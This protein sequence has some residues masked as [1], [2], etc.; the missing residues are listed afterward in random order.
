[1]KRT[2]GIAGAVLA[3]L[4]LIMG[5]AGC[6]STLPVGVFSGRQEAGTDLDLPGAGPALDAEDPAAGFGGPG[7]PGGGGGPAGPGAIEDPGVAG[8]P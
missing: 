3:V 2:T 7:S 5:V 1:M 6:L 8:E 4:A